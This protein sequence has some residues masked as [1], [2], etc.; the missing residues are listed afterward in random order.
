MS[1]SAL[2]APTSSVSTK[3]DIISQIK[4]AIRDGP[5]EPVTF[6]CP[7]PHNSDEQAT[8][9][10]S[11]YDACGDPLPV[12]R[13]RCNGARYQ[14][15][16][17]C[18]QP[19]LLNVLGVTQADLRGDQHPEY[20]TGPGTDEVPV[21]ASC[22]DDGNP[23][24][25]EP[26]R[27]AN[28][29]QVCGEANRGCSE[30]VNGRTLVCYCCDDDTVFDGINGVPGV[31]TKPGHMEGRRYWSFTKT[32]LPKWPR[33]ATPAPTRRLSDK[34][35]ADLHA[36]GLSD[37]AIQAGGFYT[38]GGPT[39][40][41]LLGWKGG[42]EVLG[43]CLIIPYRHPATGD[44]GY[45]R[46]KPDNRRPDPA[47][48]G[49]EIKYEAPK[50]GGHRA[51][52]PAGF[53]AEAL[54]DTSVS[55]LITEGEKKAAAGQQA[56]FNT[57]GLSGVDAWS[58]KRDEGPDGRKV[59]ERELITDLD[60]IAWQGRTVYIAYDSDRLDKPN[61]RQAE[62]A[63][64]QALEARG[65]KVLIVQLPAGTDGQK[66]GLDDYLVTHDPADLRHLLEQAAPPEPPAFAEADDP[67]RLAR[68]FLAGTTWRF[69]QG[70]YWE[71]T[72]THYKQVTE[73]D[74]RAR[75][76][77]HIKQVFDTDHADAIRRWEKDCRGV[78]KK[79]AARDQER[80]KP[81]PRPQ[82]PVLRKYPFTGR[83][84]QA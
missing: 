73:G 60:A 70:T 80:D 1:E 84:R 65:A 29:C 44:T 79:N 43:E 28:P 35:R 62:R 64:S 67:H 74:L 10:V 71:Y 21:R 48:P 34:H 13:V 27:V 42:A 76:T 4:A 61:V 66:V 18:K 50:G 20:L 37:A 40:A 47:D 3:S 5:K 63:L 75:L 54:T 68:S 11:G 25:W 77:A 72:G 59:G 58:V 53:P 32:A 69:W 52:F 55:L 6:P 82:K 81:L 31:V 26:C 33:Q 23:D 16:C 19:D 9:T 15:G 83:G 17:R 7:G 30:H 39:V 56:E 38:A 78:D 14:E 22:H 12:V 49:K 36:S 57:V 2:L 45:V 51:Y 24:D 8:L 46:V 41:R